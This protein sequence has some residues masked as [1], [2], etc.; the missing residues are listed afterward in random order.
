[1]ICRKCAPDKKQTGA[2]VFRV[3]P[4]GALWCEHNIN[5]IHVAADYVR[6]EEYQAVLAARNKELARVREER[7]KWKGSAV[8]VSSSASSE[9]EEL[10]KALRDI[11]Q[12]VAAALNAKEAMHDS[13]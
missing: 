7:D 6:L 3:D 10:L 1:M 12:V 13:E 8:R 11:Q 4:S 9:R 5:H 2:A